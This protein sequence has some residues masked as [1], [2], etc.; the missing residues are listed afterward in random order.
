ML[1]GCTKC[2][3]CPLAYP[4]RLQ[5]LA[6]FARSRMQVLLACTAV[7]HQS[8]RSN[9]L[10]TKKFNSAFLRWGFQSS[11]VMLNALAIVL[12]RVVELPF[13][14]APRSIAALGIFG[15]YIVW[16]KLASPERI[17]FL[18]ADHLDEPIAER[19]VRRGKVAIFVFALATLTVG[20]S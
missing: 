4:I 6:P 13:T 16:D 10:R 9:S 8:L 2:D 11:V 1:P 14:H 3:L 7:L 19:R 5:Y 12:G 17:A 20:L 18:E 15:G